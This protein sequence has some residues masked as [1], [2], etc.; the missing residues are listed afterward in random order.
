MSWLQSFDTNYTPNGKA[1]FTSGAYRVLHINCP[2]N[3]KVYDSNEN[4]VAAIVDD[5]CQEIIDSSIVTY[6][7]ENNEKLVYLP[8]SCNYKVDFFAFDDGVMTYSINEYSEVAGGITRITNYYD[9]PL[10]KGENLSGIVPSATQQELI[11]GLNKGSNIVYSLADEN[12]NNIEVSSNL[13]GEEAQ[14]AN[15]IV[16]VTANNDVCYVEGTDS[17]VSGNYAKLIAIAASGYKFNGWYE[18]NT[19]LSKDTEYRFCVTKDHN[20]L[21]MFSKNSSDSLATYIVPSNGHIHNSVLQN[22]KDATCTENGYT[23]D[24]ICSIC[25]EVIEKGKVID[26]KGHN[27]VLQNVKDATCAENGYT[28]DKICS[29]CNEV[30]EKGKVIDAKGHNSVLQNVKDAT[31]TENGYTGDKICS[32]CNEVIEKGKVIDAKGHNSVLQNVKDATCAENGYT[33]DKI[34]SICNEVIEK[35]KVIDAKGHNFKEGIC[36]VC[37]K[38]QIT[39]MSKPV[40]KKLKKGMSITDRKTK[41]IYKIKDIGRNKTV[42]YVKSTSKNAT[43]IIIPN[44][45]KFKGK[46]YK[47]IA[48]GKN[49]FKGNKKIVAVKIG[50][51]IKTIKRHAFYKCKNLRYIL[52]KTDRLK[53][54]NIGKDAFGKG[55]SNPRVKVNKNVK[56]KYMKI[57]ISRG[58]SKQALFVIT[59]QNL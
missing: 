48:I 47:V 18:N 22:V 34:C 7:N 54:S 36:I 3:V 56:K 31:C 39:D 28:G 23:G 46:T 32:I 33:G 14:S 24:K 12:N 52:V 51:N 19:L 10:I 45:I 38:K 9:V 1:I 53:F 8:A 6:I 35:G 50:K 25:N 37:N 5:K 42:E 29:I 4:L 59:Q 20:I 11:N 27:S 40:N 13:I 55:Y 26:A 58:L 30:I 49:S 2:V 43:N 21:G 41:A 15:Y 57:F 16:N 17:I 44:K